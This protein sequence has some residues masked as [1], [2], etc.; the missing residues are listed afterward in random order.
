VSDS[1]CSSSIDSKNVRAEH[2][3]VVRPVEALDVGVLIRLAGL[4]VMNDVPWAAH[5]FDKRLREKLRAVVDWIACG[6]QAPEEHQ[7]RP[8]RKGTVRGA[9]G[10]PLRRADV[11][12]PKRL[13]Q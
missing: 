2:L 7:V 3:G 6:D 1:A 9:S 8:A 13:E 4:D 12:A 5:Q 10:I 11:P